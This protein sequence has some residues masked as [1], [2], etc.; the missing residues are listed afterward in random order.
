MAPYIV[1]LTP[2]PGHKLVLLRYRLH[3]VR[4]R[5]LRVRRFHV[6]H[7]ETNGF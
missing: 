7:K 1:T 5:V 6:K 4:V 3:G 2:G